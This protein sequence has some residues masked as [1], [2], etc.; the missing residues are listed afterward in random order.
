LRAFSR[1]PS[2]EPKSRAKSRDLNAKFLAF[3]S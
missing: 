1:R 2:R 3:S